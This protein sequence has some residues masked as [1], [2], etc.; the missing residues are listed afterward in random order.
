RARWPSRSPCAAG[1]AGPGTRPSPCTPCPTPKHGPAEI[2]EL[3]VTHRVVPASVADGTPVLRDLLARG[4]D[5]VYYS[6]TPERAAEVARYLRAKRFTGPRFLDPSSAG[7]AFL[8]AA[9][10]AAEGWQAVLSCS[11]PAAPAGRDFATAYERRHRAEPGPWAVEAY[12]AV[13]L[14]VDRLT[15]LAGSGARR[16]ERDALTEALGE[17]NYRG[18]AGT[19]SFNERR[20]LNAENVYLHRVRDGRFRY[21]DSLTVQGV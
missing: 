5:S 19:Y 18:I 6:G 14:V 21:A 15:A 7:E 13:R 4:A 9:G 11:D 10:D 20:W 16:P 12:D 2:A 3:T 8:T 17:A 1:R